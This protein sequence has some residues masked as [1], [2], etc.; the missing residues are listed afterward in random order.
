M[1]G[2]KIIETI[3][4]ELFPAW[5]VIAASALLLVC[6]AG[7]TWGYV[8]SIRRKETFCCLSAPWLK[9]A[10][11][12]LVVTCCITTCISVHAGADETATYHVIEVDE[13]AS[14]DEIHQ[15]FNIISQDG[16]CYKVTYRRNY[17][18]GKT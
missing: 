8:V 6:A 15:T 9:F 5:M 4:M 12:L 11:W 16:N 17:N 7:F 1:Q 3:T 10:C 18:A 14:M 13:A 2:V